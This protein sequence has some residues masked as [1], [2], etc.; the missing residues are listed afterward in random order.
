VA[1]DCARWMMNILK[2]AFGFGFSSKLLI[3]PTQKAYNMKSQLTLFSFHFFP[4]DNNRKGTTS[5]SHT[6]NWPESVW[7]KSNT[8]R[9]RTNKFS[10]TWFCFWTNFHQKYFYAYKHVVWEI[11]TLVNCCV[12]E[13]FLGFVSN[14]SILCLA[15]NW[16]HMLYDYGSRGNADQF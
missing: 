2:V 15:I 9:C 4:L 3:V 14:R 8:F 11:L 13:N 12:V 6:K 10:W 1:P 5:A 7:G 16:E